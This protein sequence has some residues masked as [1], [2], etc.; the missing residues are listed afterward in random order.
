MAKRTFK[1]SRKLTG[2]KVFRK[3]DD[4]KVGDLF[5]GKFAD[6]YTD[7]KYNKEVYVFDVE[8]CTFNADLAGKQLALNEMGMFS[9]AMEKVS[10]GEF[11]QFTYNGKDQIEKGKFAGKEAHTCEVLVLEEG[12]EDDSGEDGL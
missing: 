9:K 2:A 8:E 12:D 7:E 1:T 3:W 11:I 5:I 4:W 10:K 6:Q